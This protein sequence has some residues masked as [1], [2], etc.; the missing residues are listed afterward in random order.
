[1]KKRIFAAFASL[2][3]LASCA[4]QD[5]A[6]LVPAG[7]ERT[8]TL[9]VQN[10]ISDTAADALVTFSEKVADISGGSLTVETTYCGDTIAALDAGC[11]LIFADNAE[12]ARA[13]SD[14]SAF[15]SPF[16]FYDY[17]H[18]TTTL[19][20]EAFFS[21]ISERLDSLLGASPLA[22]F[23]GGSRAFASNE[24]EFL[25]VWDAWQGMQVTIG[26][27]STLLAVVLEGLGASLSERDDEA[28]LSGFLA[29]DYRTVEC[30]AAALS[31]ITDTRIRN[32]RVYAYRSFHT[33]RICW[34][35][36]GNGTR[37]SLSD[38]ELA[39]ITEAAAAALAQNDTAIY[40]AEEEAFA[41]L[42]TLGV[43]VFETEYDEF[44][45]QAT[46]IFRSGVRYRNLWDWDVYENLRTMC[47]VE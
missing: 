12:I 7:E 19:N 16:Y 9:C 1:M 27:D 5:A 45:A 38:Y 8:L 29:G 13:D 22:A 32:E 33:A 39:V 11:D 23:Y 26:R 43:P 41:A 42:E 25:D 24:S 40:S 34:L 28:V 15:T 36:L 3:L 4:V 44:N 18:M 2:L 10:G 14:F 47:M 6:E 30:D 46:D 17:T 20:S 21:S 31:R 35:M 37:D